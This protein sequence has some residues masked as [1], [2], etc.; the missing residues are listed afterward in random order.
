M[1]HLANITVFR[2]NYGSET[3][4]YEKMHIVDAIDNVDVE[5]KL[6]KYYK[7]MDRV[8]KNIVN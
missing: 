3:E 4:T 6:K 5:I 2:R 1:L 8:V 7:E